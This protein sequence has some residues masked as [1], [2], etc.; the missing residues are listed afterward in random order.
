MSSLRK[1]VAHGAA[2]MM[3][4]RLVDRSFGLIS[5]MVLA[6]LLVPADFGIVA[7]ATSL[8]ALLELF[9]AFGL[10]VALIQRVNATRVHFDTVWT[11][12]V[13][14][15]VAIAMCLVIL[16]WPLSHF[17]HEPRL[18]KLVCVLALGSAVQG[19]ENVGVVYFRKEMNFDREFRFLAAKRLITFCVSV[20][21][22]LALR[23]YWSLALSMTLGRITGVAMSYRMH[24]YRPRF[25]L[26]ALRELMHFS[27]WVFAQNLFFLLKERS[28]DFIVGRIAGPYSLGILSVSME[29]AK[30]PGTEL[31]APINRAALPAYS[32]VA[33]EPPRIAQQY[34]T[35]TS[36]IVLFVT[37]FV[38]GIGA[39]GTVVAALLLGPKWHEAS[40]LISVVALVG[41]ANVLINSSHPPIL[42][43]GKPVI[44]AK[45]TALQV[46]IEVPAIIFLTLHFGVLG[47]AYGYAVSAV[48]ILPISLWL[49][50]GALNVRALEFVGNIWRPLVAAGVMY[51]CV[52]LAMPPVD[53]ATIGTLGGLILVAKFAPLGAAVYA[54]TEALLWLLCKRPEGPELIVVEQLVMRWT[55][56]RDRLRR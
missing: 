30:M 18:V 24:P 42:A 4:Y 13:A 51:L 37:P 7:M 34:L 19:F 31:V 23:S 50:L 26:A 20:T 44:Y 9:Y 48:V 11:L 47:A 49:V 39:L 12:N 46:C 8:I 1:G 21:L 2:W 5:T 6:R 36:L 38:A 35:I 16:A 28:C 25:S 53:A 41:V 27:K 45:I 22:A 52:K 33:H 43:I 10:D 56:L 40:T 55:M 32:R 54:A 14:A 3:L 17:Y 29:I 15:G